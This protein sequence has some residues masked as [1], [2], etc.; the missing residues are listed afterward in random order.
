M[1]GPSPPVIL[2]FLQTEAVKLVDYMQRPSPARAVLL[3]EFIERRF[4]SNKDTKAQGA[5]T[6]RKRFYSQEA[7]DVIKQ[8][9]RRPQAAA[10]LFGFYNAVLFLSVSLG[11]YRL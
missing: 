10:A 5:A 3:R 7:V 8:V 1:T 6:K 4:S 2:F 9:A 11:P